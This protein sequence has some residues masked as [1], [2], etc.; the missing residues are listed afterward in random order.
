MTDNTVLVEFCA[1]GIVRLTLNRPKA[2]NALNAQ[3]LDEF[4]QALREN[5][6]ARII[7]LGGAG[8]RAFCAGEDL[9]QSLAPKTGTPAELRDAFWKLQDITRLTSSSSAIVIAAVQGFAI[10]GGAEIALAADFVIGGPNAKFRFPEASIGHAVTGGISLRL[11]QLVGLPKS[12]E[13]LLTGKY[14]GAEEALQI[15][16]LNEVVD[17]PKQRALELAYE[18]A[19]LPAV[20]S[21]ACKMSLERAV[22]PNM[23]SCLHDEVNVANYCF[24]QSDAEQAFANFA[25]RKDTRTTTLTTKEGPEMHHHQQAVGRDTTDESYVSV[26][27]INSAWGRAVSRFPTR[28]FLRFS[29]KDISFKD[30]DSLV[31]KFAGGLKHLG[32]KDGDRILVIMQNS[33]EMVCS[34]LATNRLGAVWVP[35]NTQLKSVTLAHVVQAAQPRLTLVDRDFLADLQAVNVLDSASIWVND[36]KSPNDLSIISTLGPPQAEC[37]QAS[38]STTAAFLYTS[39]TTGKSKPCILSHGYFIQ[40]ASTLIAGC[41]LIEDDVLY[42]PFP[43]FHA[44]ATA[45]TVIPAILLGATAAL[46]TRFSA[47]RFWDEIRSTNATVYDFMGATLALTYKQPHSTRDREHRVRLAWGFPIPSF[48][49]EYESRFGHP[50]ITLYGSVEASLPI[51]QD[52]SRGGQLPLGSCGRVRPGYQL[53][54]ANEM[55]EEVPADTPG[56]MLLRSDSPTAFFDG[57]FNDPTSTITAFRN[58]WLHTGDIGKVDEDGNVFFLGR[59]KDLI[60]RRGE[61]VNAAEVEEEFLQHE[62]VVI[63]V[64]CGIPSDLGNGAEEDVKVVVELRDGSVV[65]ERDL[66]GWAVTHMARFQVPSVVQ[67]VD[68]IQKTPT[69]KLEKH[70]LAV[71]GG[72][73]FDIRSVST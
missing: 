65:S 50:L 64:A 33:A 2:L 35:V 21:S 6:N 26:K 8:D 14:V 70:S 54:I 7:I 59:L 46:S 71:E 67:I 24:A 68:K 72:Q 18:L 13:L 47:N 73:R 15:G 22:F 39:G 53:R 29:G 19:N 30:F 4:V 20:S 32:I 40:Q 9:K 27:D 16:L 49:P 25:S 34:W 42:C 58:L 38:S 3:L 1:P 51:F 11:P 10:G 55:D 69:G 52:Y 43:L 28:T 61:N 48:A 45:L 63:A 36:C 66:W 56:Q 12:K 60:R 37:V 44:D 62:D 23:E 17:D 31:T 5:T 57:Y 41:G